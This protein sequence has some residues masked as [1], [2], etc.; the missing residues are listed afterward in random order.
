MSW[1]G[2]PDKAWG[3]ESVALV[4]CDGQGNGCVL[5]TGGPAVAMALEE[6]G[7]GLSDIGLDDAPKGLSVWFGRLVD[8]T[9]GATSDHPEEPDAELH[10]FFEPLTSKQW[11]QLK[12]GRLL[13]DEA[14]WG[15]KEDA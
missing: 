5:Q 8:T 1:G 13:W 4:A 15:L 9:S 14:E 7:R 12:S 2:Y 6:W 3:K 10:G 11:D